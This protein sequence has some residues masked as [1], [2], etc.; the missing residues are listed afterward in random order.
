MRRRPP[1]STRTDT[2]FP[3]TTLF[4]SSALEPVGHALDVHHLLVIGAVVVHHVQDR[5]A[6]MRRR[7]QRAG[8]IEKVAVGLDVDDDAL[9]VAMPQRQAHPDADP[10]AD[11]PAAA[12][13]DQP[14]GVGDGPQ[15]E[16]STSAHTDLICSKYTIFSLTTK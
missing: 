10:G 2:L 12:A 6:V 9:L 8:R 16:E 3:Y 4:R 5:D 11:R 14:R 1:R 13:A 7:P 15:S